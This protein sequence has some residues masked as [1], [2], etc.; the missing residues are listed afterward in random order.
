MLR[1]VALADHHPG[2]P[3]RV[4]GRSV[5]HDGLLG[6]NAATLQ[7]IANAMG[8]IHKVEVIV[9]S[10]TLDLDAEAA[11]GEAG[12]MADAVVAD[13]GL[14]RAIVLAVVAGPD[15]CDGGAAI[16][17]VEPLPGAEI[18]TD[19]IVA[20]RM[21][22][23]LASCDPQSAALGGLAE[24]VS[25]L[26]GIDRPEDPI[27]ARRRAALPRPRD[28]PRRLRLRQASSRRRRSPVPRR[29]ST[30][31]EARTGAEVV[32]YSQIVDYG[33]TTEEADDHAQALMDQWGVGRK[34]FDDGLVILFDLDPSLLHGQVQLYGGPGYR[35]A[36]LDNSEKQRIFDED[37]LPR[38]R[39]GG[40]RRGA[41]DRARAGRRERHPRA[42]RASSRRPAR[43]T[44]RWA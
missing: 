40:P 1:P 18:D 33:I 13:W 10:R 12:A 6:N 3:D 8:S 15:G 29:R 43:S 39:D 30:R 5:Y 44:R 25:G 2:I 32:V 19:R 20:D 35:A 4:E 22:P 38:L 9:V 42:R 37:M 16:A 21:G 31:I 7:N 26:T 11:A 14:S 41:P 24:I 27:A 34:G 23:S 28:R 17:T 36:F